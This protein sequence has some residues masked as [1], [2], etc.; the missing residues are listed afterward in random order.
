MKLESPRAFEW[1]GSAEVYWSERR[2]GVV[3][4]RGCFQNFGFRG[5][6]G[7]RGSSK[8]WNL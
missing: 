7:F 2:K 6:R 1:S 5:F 4:I 3:L 8:Y